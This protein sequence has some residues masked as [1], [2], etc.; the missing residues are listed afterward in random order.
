VLPWNWYKFVINNPQKN[1]KKHGMFQVYYKCNI[2][3]Y[4]LVQVRNS[5]K[6]NYHTITTMTPSVVKSP[7]GGSRGA[8]PAHTPPK[9]GKNMIFWHK[10]VI[11][12]TQ[13][14]PKNFTPPSA[15]RNFFK[16]TPP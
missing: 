5:C 8:H 16:Y 15:R 14:T 7:R 11:F 13:N 10:I 9:I 12:F 2:T 4:I 1:N 6:S 3:L